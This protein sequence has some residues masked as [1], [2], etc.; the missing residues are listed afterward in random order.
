MGPDEHHWPVDNSVYTNVIAALSMRTAEYAALLAG[1]APH[2]Q[3]QKVASAMLVEYC[4]KYSY[5]P[6]YDNY[7]RGKAIVSFI[8]S[9]IH[10]FVTIRHAS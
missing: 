7:T 4:S 3:W 1:A 6:E 8:H 2:P 5:H 9:F 10:S